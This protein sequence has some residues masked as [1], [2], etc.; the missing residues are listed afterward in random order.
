[1]ENSQTNCPHKL[2]KSRLKTD[3]LIQTPNN[4]CME[5]K[6]RLLVAN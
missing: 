2:E 3:F 1:M 6:R 5:A 4:L